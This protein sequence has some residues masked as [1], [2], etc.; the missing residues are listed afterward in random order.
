MYFDCLGLTTAIMK[1][2]FTRTQIYSY[3][4]KCSQHSKVSFELSQYSSRKLLFSP[5]ETQIEYTHAVLLHSYDRLKSFK[6]NG[7][8]K[9]MLKLI[10]EIN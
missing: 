4:Y 7:C 6:I 8:K 10:F 1:G 5:N 2:I 3:E 9:L